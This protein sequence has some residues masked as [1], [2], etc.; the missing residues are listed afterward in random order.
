MQ[1][2]AAFS[3]R[4][5]VL[6]YYVLTFAISWSAILW[7][8]VRGGIPAT[9]EEMNAVLPVAIVAMLL[10]PSAAGLLMT[11]LVDGRAGFRALGS[12][13][14]KW[15][16]SVRWYVIAIF[17][18]P[19]VLLVGFVALAQFS[20]VYLPGIFTADD[21]S[22]RLTMGILAGLAVGI[23]E[24]FGWTGFATPK[25]RLRHS[26]LFTGIIMGVLWGAWHIAGHVVLASGA[27]SAPL[28]PTV[29]ILARGLG[30]LVGQLVAIR[31]LIVWVHDRTGSLLLAMLMHWTYTASTMIL[32]PTGIAGVPLMIYDVVA[33]L[34]MWIVVAAVAVIN[35]GTIEARRPNKDADRETAPTYRR[36]V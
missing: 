15:R 18:I 22:S 1:T 32:E 28:S 34:T 21:K 35:R 3:K 19:L 25:L 24:E 16:V 11:G 5:P 6:I 26:I 36:T 9:K 8:I 12:R 29:Y 10:G 14:G 17:L 2:I 13:L 20:P 23:C 31:V 33:A 7:V 27:Y 4:Y 30:F